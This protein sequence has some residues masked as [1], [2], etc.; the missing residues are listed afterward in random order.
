MPEVEV[1][2]VGG[3]IIVL[4][5]RFFFFCCCCCC[6]CFFCLFHTLPHYNS[7]PP[8]I[9]NRPIGQYNVVYTI[10]WSNFTTLLP[11]WMS[12]ECNHYSIIMMFEFFFLLQS[13]V[14]HNN[15]SACTRPRSAG[16]QK[17]LCPACLYIGL[18]IAKKWQI[19][20]LI[21]FLVYH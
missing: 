17:L 10:K 21:I 2:R 5:K 9:K 6:C 15:I 7:C 14:F 16:I 13:S 8:N 11:P 18:L 4:L 19:R 3:G 20:Y 1:D 12:F